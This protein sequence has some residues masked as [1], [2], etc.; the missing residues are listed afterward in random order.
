MTHEEKHQG[1]RAQL[2]L[3]RERMNILRRYG[4]KGAAA[5]GLM[6]WPPPAE[7]GF[8][9]HFPYPK[10]GCGSYPSKLDGPVRNCPQS[11]LNRPGIGLANQMP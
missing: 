10:A 6:Q 7:S 2:D 8:D 4:A 3:L 11:G 5:H 1:S 9:G